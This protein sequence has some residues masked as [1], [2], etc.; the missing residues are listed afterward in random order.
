MEKLA[1]ILIV[2]D[3]PDTVGLIELTL[4]PA[5]YELSLAYS[6]EEA[7]NMLRDE[8]ID[9]LLLDVMMPEITGFEVVR[10]LSEENKNIPPIIFL[11]AKGQQKDI[12]EGNALGAAG[13]LVKPA[14][15]GQLLDA[16]G[17]ALYEAKR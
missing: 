3:E 4:R 10:L 15:R 11:S 9:L 2:D 5:G 12:D 14:T 16:I 8:A 13:Y 7:L 6:G 17:A 1:K